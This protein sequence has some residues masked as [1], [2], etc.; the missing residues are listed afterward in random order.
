MTK[1]ARQAAEATDYAEKAWELARTLVFEAPSTLDGN[2]IVAFC[3]PR[4]L[5]ALQS[6]HAAGLAKG[7][8]AGFERGVRVAAQAVEDE[9]CGA[10]IN[11]CSPLQ[12]GG[13]VRRAVLALLPSQPTEPPK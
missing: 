2:K 7:D 9:A 1:D 8:A 13:R 3:T 5:A 4:I 12:V 10:I 11:D 6:A